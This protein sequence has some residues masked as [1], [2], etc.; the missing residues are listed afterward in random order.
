MD[1]TNYIPG[2]VLED[3]AR[4][5]GV[6]I[7]GETGTGVSVELISLMKA[8][9]RAGK[10]IILVDPYGDL[11]QE[12]QKAH[13][14]VVVWQVGSADSSY[15]VNLF[16]IGQ[17]S[18]EFQVAERI[19]DLMYSLFDPQHTGILG[20]RFEHAARNTIIALLDANQGSFLNMAKM[21]TNEA[22]LQSIVPYIKHESVRNYFTDQLAHTSDFHKSEVLDYIVSKL[23]AF[24]EP[25]SIIGNITKVSEE[26]SFARLFEDVN[27]S[28]VIDLS[29]LLK[30]PSHLQQV[31]SLILIDQLSRTLK[32]SMTLNNQALYIDEVKRFNHTHLE[33]ILTLSVKKEMSVVYSVRS[34]S[35]LLVEAQYVCLAGKT[36][37][38]YRIAPPDAKI[39]SPYFEGFKTES[40]IALLPNFH[41]AARIRTNDGVSFIEN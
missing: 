24:I 36:I 15:S 1:Q 29:L 10:R 35:N 5:Y 12:L 41:F 32:E 7:L 13:D 19:I 37:I 9:I 28:V 39:V 40:E 4:K 8:D 23:S 21:L 16:T 22:F 18:D 11:T 25:T 31:V 2:P 38:V 14:N 6:C 34:I 3:Y 26:S 27:K 30:Q 33:S 20:P 17:G